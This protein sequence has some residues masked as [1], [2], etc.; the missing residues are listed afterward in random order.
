LLIDYNDNNSV[1]SFSEKAIALRAFYIPDLLLADIGL[2]FK[3][4]DASFNAIII[5][6]K[7][8]KKFEMLLTDFVNQAISYG[9]EV[10]LLLRDSKKA[11]VFWRL[12]AKLDLSGIILE[13]NQKEHKAIIRLLKEFR[14]AVEYELY[15]GLWIKEEAELNQELCQLVDFIVSETKNL[16]KMTNQTFVYHYF[17]E[18]QSSGD[19]FKDIIAGKSIFPE[20]G[21]PHEKDLD[22]LLINIRRALYII[23]KKCVIDNVDSEK[24]LKN[25]IN[26]LFQS[27]HASY[28]NYKKIIRI[29][30]SIH[31]EKL[32]I[33][34]DA[35]NYIDYYINI[36]E[37]KSKNKYRIDLNKKK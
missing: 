32:L 25:F 26:E 10:Y 29:L 28:G 11:N 36:L 14:L 4:K 16:K 35:R 19:I 9:L 3:L 6:V 17:P 13:Y 30:G 20:V 18:G 37:I 2:L 31:H 12:F 34:Q 27:L 1:I 24:F 33:N 8:K 5:E 21:L 22:F 7:N 15:S 23:L